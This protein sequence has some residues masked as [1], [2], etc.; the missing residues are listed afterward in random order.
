MKKI[1]EKVIAYI[2]F[3]AV[4]ILFFNKASLLLIRKGNGYGTDILNF[5]KQEEN[6][7]NVLILGSSHSY[8][9][10][11]PYLIEEKTGLTAYDFCT[12]Q[13]PIWITYYYF[14]EALKT[15]KPQY[16]ILD[17]HMLLIGN[18]DYAE[19]SVNR[20]AIDKMKMSK[21]KIDAIKTSVE[22]REDRESYYF[23]IIKYHT[24]YKELNSSDIEVV[25]KGKTIDNKGYKNL[26]ESHYIFPGV[27]VNTTDT[28]D[29]YDKNLEFFYKIVDLAKEKNIELIVIKTPAYY[30]GDMI[31]KLNSV[32]KIAEEKNIFFL[33]Y[34]ERINTLNLDYN[35]DFYDG[36][37]LNENGSIKFT[38]QLIK[39]LGW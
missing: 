29:I 15:Q 36:G 27:D 33:N 34:I 10:V 25:F 23:N 8:S 12:Q 4:L 2:C 16:V 11:N 21:N 35:S 7:I 3:F 1:I 5:Y 14:K 17:I 22:K 18:S 19:D 30:E 13:Q 9:A 24:R 28:M 39:D 26:P 38:N 6:S 37:H 31:K 20:D 32:T